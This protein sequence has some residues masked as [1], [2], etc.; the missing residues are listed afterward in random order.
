MP[1]SPT[2]K[3]PSADMASGRRKSRTQLWLLSTLALVF[4]TS[5]ADG[6]QM[7]VMSAPNVL[8]VGRMENIF[9]ECQDCSSDDDVLVE[10]SVMQFP[11]K[12][13]RF[14]SASVNLTKTNKF[15]A[16]GKIKIPDG[17]FSKDPY[18]SQHVYL[19]ARFPDVE[20]EKVILV[21]FQF[22][23]IFIQTD[24]TLYTPNSKA[25]SSQTQHI[26]YVF[27][28]GL[29]QVVA[30]FH[31]K[32]QMS[33]SAKFEVKEYVLPSF[34]VKLIP[35]SS[36]F[37]VNSEAL[38]ISIKATYMFDK[39]VDGSAFGV[40]GVEHEGQKKSFP[41]SLQRVVIEKG[42]GSV[43]LKREHVTQTFPNVLDLVG[44][45]IYVAVSVLTDSGSEMAEAELKNI[46][47][48]TSPYTIHFKKT[49]KFFKPGIS[50]DV[51]IEVTNP[52][53]TPAQGVPLVM[54][55]DEVEGI[56][57]ANG[58]AMLSIN[59][60][61]NSEPL[62]ITAKTTDPNIALEMQASA[63][64]T[65][66][67]YSSSNN[68]YI[69]IG[70]GRPEVTLGDNLKINLNFNQRENAQN[71]ITTLILSRGQ[72]VRFG[73]YWTRGQTLLSLII[74]IS[75]DIMP[76]FRIIAYYHTPENE[77]VSDSVW[78][79][80][81]DSCLGSLKLE[82]VNPAVYYEPRK[83][84]GLKVT[85]DPGA[86][87]GLVAVDKGVYSLNNQHRLTQ[88]KVWDTVEEYDTGCTP[89]GGKDSMSVFY[90]AGLVFESNTGG[91]TPYREGLKCP[92][93][94]RSKRTTDMMNITSSLVSQYEDELQREC[95]L[96]GMRDTPVSYPCERR[97]EYIVDGAACVQAFLH[98]C[99]E[100]E[101]QRAEKSKDSLKLGHS[102]EDNNSYVDT[103]EIVSRTNFPQSWLWT[104][105]KLPICFNYNCESSSFQK[106]FPL[107]DSITKWMFTGIS[108][109][110]TLG[111][112]VAEPL[113]VIVRK[114]FFVDL[115][116]PYSV[117]RGE[118]VEIKAVL[119]NYQS[120]AVTVRVDLL[121]VEDVC[122]S[123]SRRGKYRQ[124]VKVGAQATQAVPFVIIPTGVGEYRIEI[125][126]AVKDS[127]LSDGIVK[128]LLVVPE[129]FLIKS[130][131]I[132]TLD[133]E[134]KGEDGKQ[135]EVINSAIPKLDLL[136]NTPT[137]TQISL[138][139]KEYE[140]ELKNDIGGAPM[141]GLV[142]QPSGCG[143]ENMIHMT[144]PLIATTYLDKSK[145]WDPVHIQRRYEALQHISTGYHNQLHY[146][147]KDGSFA[148]DSDHES[149]TWLTAYV[150]KV[151]TMAKNLVFIQKDVICDAVQFLILKA[152][153]SNGMFSES[154]RVSNREMTGDVYGKD[155]D[156]SI[157][158]FC[159]IAMQDSHS[160]CASTVDNL[161]E[162]I[163]RAVSYLEKRLPSLIHPY[164]I[165]MASCALAKE[166]KLNQEILYTFASPD[167]SHWPAPGGR[168]YTLEATAYSL[169]ALVRA[170]A[171]KQAKP[172]VRW[173]NKQ[174][175]SVDGGY[176]ST[177]AT[178]M[179]YQAVADYWANA[180]E[181]DYDL[182]VDILLPSRSKP[183]KYNFNNDNHYSTRTAKTNNINQDVKV[184]ATGT[185][186][187]TLTMVSLYYTLPTEREG[188]CFTFNMSVVLIPE[189][190]D[191]DEK[192]YQLKIKVLYKD[193]ERDAAMTVLDIGLLTGFT[194]NTKDLD[195]LSKGRARTISKYKMDSTES[196]RGS[197]IIF[198]DK[199]SHRQPEEIT[200]RIHQ[201]LKVGVLQPAAVSVYEHNHQQNKTH[202]V[203]FYH[204]E[205]RAGELLRLCKGDEC[206]CAE[207]N[208]S[209]QKKGK[210]NNDE[211]TAKV[212]ETEVN[213]RIDFVYKVH[214]E[215]F[216]DA[217]STD[218]YTMRVLDVIKE[219][220]SDVGSQGKLRTF[221]SYPHC[222]ATLNLGAGKSYLIMG[223]S[224]NVYTDDQ[225][226]IHRY[227]LGERMW[228]EYW[229][230][231]A[232]C[233]T[234]KHNVTC[235][236]IDEMV[237]K[238]TLHGCQH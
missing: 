65:A 114:N 145:Q 26:I 95:C 140:H 38:T 155:S 41:S 18:L 209:M 7:L 87:V 55:K 5:Q 238:F 76:S 10:I 210:I 236:G 31:S 223:T 14:A 224:K 198:L 64:M 72:L 185:G 222:R 99:E 9:V 106:R 160:L 190:M 60:V 132:V 171:F 135:V 184:T 199:V 117:V 1:S 50:F 121:E 43:T 159:L 143:E 232:E 4:L 147:K 102:E 124:E 187:A 211:R 80:V 115:K 33:F 186:E 181:N 180:N 68:N 123:A 27:S 148:K 141:G 183:Y 20:L 98:C 167:L 151:F 23:Y 11:T 205:R 111:I 88:K 212:C 127:P 49:P 54:D 69:H 8:R 157:T 216:T 128:S 13:K 70:M 218:I 231:D 109:S 163:Q 162:S 30:R 86:T 150:V 90:D 93:P 182:M 108:L 219:G 177:Q 107:Q 215:E 83:M 197:L 213:S 85:G 221:L 19:Q 110:N 24:K 61:K 51:S 139:G 48:V 120:D 71:D 200:F 74:P 189:K 234:E 105:F 94:S 152:Q 170:K 201:K 158:A 220:S 96:D 101:K 45:S 36:F 137:S 59:T 192:I 179:V 113:E 77:V 112:C 235:S 134:N 129:G 39:M 194:V 154:G 119:H 75:K 92:A 118:Q 16:F 21:S 37:Y 47:I 214:M 138:T 34:E 226:H 56:T 57:A 126:A 228:I 122:S 206:T 62:T 42:D 203:R 172:I 168:A 237:Q 149:S 144:L 6:A 100:M 103:N 161:P 104:E 91:G 191:D 227:V 225:G 53:G 58:V 67:P 97:S 175:R 202:C 136:P 166:D 81:K 32:P 89:G 2:K 116:L 28:P 35:K 156:A 66:L 188:D 46:P 25:L 22:G 174:H 229:P 207:E 125:K 131:Q 29:W 208:C 12:A 44:S 52:D 176:G 133:P 84:F 217:L 165:A 178:M 196:E 233:Q 17:D 204:P 230:T 82:P 63:S 169:M 79:D 195:L 15:Q 78:V 3:Q 40:F 146:R 164:A 153:Q 73:R 142:Y 193:K 173:F 130:S